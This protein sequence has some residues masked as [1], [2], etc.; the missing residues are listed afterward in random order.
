MPATKSAAASKWDWKTDLMGIF[1]TMSGLAKL[2]SSKPNTAAIG[3]WGILE[4]VR[5]LSESKGMGTYVSARLFMGKK[6][7][8][9]TKVDVPLSFKDSEDVIT[10]QW[11]TL[12]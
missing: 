12:R 9:K 10:S 6:K 3:N 7:F 1:R 2:T 5:L 11:E 8:A 4:G